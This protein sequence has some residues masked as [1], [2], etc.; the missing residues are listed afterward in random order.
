MNVLSFNPWCCPTFVWQ[1][2]NSKCIFNT[3]QKTDNTLDHR[4]RF[5][6]QQLTLRSSK[7]LRSF[8]PP[9]LASQN[10]NSFGSV[11]MI[12]HSAQLRTTEKAIFESLLLPRKTKEVTDVLVSILSV[13]TIKLFKFMSV[14]VNHNQVA[15]MLLLIGL[16]Q[17]KGKM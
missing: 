4:F 15:F 9:Y 7:Q 6:H 2:T 16:M 3:F 5:N 14:T 8:V 1:V 17:M 10:H 11:L 13:I 12:N